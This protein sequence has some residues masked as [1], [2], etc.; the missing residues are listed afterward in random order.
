MHAR[1]HARTQRP[2]EHAPRLVHAGWVGLEALLELLQV[3]DAGAVIKAVLELAERHLRGNRGLRRVCGGCGAC[4]G[5]SC[6][7]VSGSVRALVCRSGGACECTRAAAAAAAAAA[8]H[9]GA[10]R[11][12]HAAQHGKPARRC[13]QHARERVLRT[14]ARTHARTNAHP[15]R[16]VSSALAAPR[17]C[18]S[19][20]RHGCCVWAHRRAPAHAHVAPARPR[21]RRPRVTPCSAVVLAHACHADPSPARCAP[22]CVRTRC[23]AT[24]AATW[25]GCT[26]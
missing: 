26:L 2:E 17:R 13:N 6:A 18:A 25:W 16:A 4:A 14:H 24:A 19:R 1:A 5:A 21:S 9:R 12:Q 11:C 23:L 8:A 15:M 20:L 10:L 7:V 3:C 22:R